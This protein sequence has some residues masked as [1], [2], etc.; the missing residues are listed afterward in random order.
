MCKSGGDAIG[1]HIGSWAFGTQHRRN[2]RH[3]LPHV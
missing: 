1:W 2:K 3:R